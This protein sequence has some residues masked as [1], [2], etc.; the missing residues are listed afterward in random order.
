[1]EQKC[2]LDKQG[3][4]ARIIRDIIMHFSQQPRFWIGWVIIRV[5]FVSYVHKSA[6]LEVVS[7]HVLYLILYHQGIVLWKISKRNNCVFKHISKAILEVDIL[8]PRNEIVEHKSF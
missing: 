5:L 7:V 4:M 8:L 1:M 6:Y 2:M 3:V